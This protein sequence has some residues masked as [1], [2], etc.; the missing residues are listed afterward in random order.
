VLAQNH[1][2]IL[3]KKRNPKGDLLV[4][5]QKNTNYLSWEFNKI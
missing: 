3:G 2:P 1:V 4:K 5:L